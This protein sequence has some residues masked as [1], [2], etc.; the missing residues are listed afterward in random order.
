M[1]KLLEL[2][3]PTDY[4]KYRTLTAND[5]TGMEP[6]LVDVMSDGRRLHDRRLSR[7]TSLRG[8]RVCQAPLAV[9]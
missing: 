7:E 8:G 4:A 2:R 1:E 9:L 6:L 3:H 5:I